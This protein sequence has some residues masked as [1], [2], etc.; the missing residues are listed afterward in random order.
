MSKRVKIG[1]LWATVTGGK[2]DCS[3]E[4]TMDVG[5]GTV[6]FFEDCVDCGASLCFYVPSCPPDFGGVLEALW[7][8]D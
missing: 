8:E 4:H 1:G 7:D 3:H 2:P 5:R 6:T